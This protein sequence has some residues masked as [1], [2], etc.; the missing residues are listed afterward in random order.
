VVVVNRFTNQ[1]DVMKCGDLMHT[2]L[3]WIAGNA[4]VR[5]VARLMRDRALGFL[6]VSGTEPGQLAGVV[7]DRDLAV[8]VCTEERRSQDVK[9]LDVASTEVIVCGEEENL[10]VAEKMMR[11]EQKSRLVIV[12]AAGRPVGILSLTDVLLGDHPRRAI[13]TAK[14]VLAREADGPHTPID[15]IRLTPSTFEDEEAVSRLDSVFVG[16]TVPTTAKVFP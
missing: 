1:E 6:L 11:D 10:A 7:T 9:I 14:G 3:Q 2:D 8:R 12:N 15:Q 5:D 16:R 4:N 13:K